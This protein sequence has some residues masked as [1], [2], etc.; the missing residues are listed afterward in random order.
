MLSS[1]SKKDDVQMPKIKLH[2]FEVM[3]EKIEEFIGP[4]C[5]G[6]GYA[7]VQNGSLKKTGSTGHRR[8]PSNGGFLDYTPHT[9]Q[10]IF[11][12]TKTIT[13]ATTIAVLRKYNKTPDERIKSYFPAFGDTS[14]VPNDITFGDLMNH[15]SG[16]SGTK[17]RFESMKNYIEAGEFGPRGEYDY[18]NINY[19]LL[20]LLVPMINPFIRNLTMGVGSAGSEN[21]VLS[22]AFV[23]MARENV[24]IPANINQSAG[25]SIWDMADVSSATRLYDFENQAT[26]GVY[27]LASDAEL[28]DFTELCG[29]GGWY[30]NTI[31]MASIIDKLMRKKLNPLIDTDVMKSNQ[32][33]VF[34]NSN[35][36]AGVG[37][38]YV[39]TG[40]SG[41]AP[42]GLTIWVYLENFGISVVVFTNS[43]NNP[44]L[45]NSLLNEVLS[46]IAESYQYVN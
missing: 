19:T 30:L 32:Y 20:R 16:F 9:R 26:P 7:I 8:L 29:G 40:L 18:A 33:G 15:R 36:T 39:H 41:S 38:Y 13:A 35:N 31:E 43:S 14:A 27:I 23:Q 42:G 34:Y 24:T 11:S 6:M 3:G 28:H 12:T 21:F 22:S 10:T 37:N 46:A 45:G 4:H 2:N 5:V 17:D 1:C 25:P 44:V